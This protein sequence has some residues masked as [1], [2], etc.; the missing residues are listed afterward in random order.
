MQKPARSG[1]RLLITGVGAVGVAFMAPSCDSGS[2]PV[3]VGVIV[4]DTGGSGVAG[5]GSGGSGSG[6][7]G[8]AVGTFPSGGAP[9]GAA[10]GAAGHGGSGSGGTGGY[11]GTGGATMV[12]VAV[13]PL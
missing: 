6:G 12:G 3:Q 8:G 10:G 4:T 11:P 2:P 5:S 7:S 9:G 1:K 13:Q